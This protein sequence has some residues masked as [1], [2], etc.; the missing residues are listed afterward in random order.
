MGKSIKRV[1]K[2]ACGNLS[3][4]IR[5]CEHGDHSYLKYSKGCSGFSSDYIDLPPFTK[6]NEEAKGLG[7]TGE[8]T[9]VGRVCWEVTWV[10]SAAR[11]SAF[12][13]SEMEG[14]E[15]C[16]VRV[17]PGQTWFVKENSGPWWRISVWTRAIGGD[18]AGRLFQREGWCLLWSWRVVT[19][20][21]TNY[22]WRELERHR[23]WLQ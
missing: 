15:G 10:R 20:V 2:W 4:S 21:L 17:W 22:T 9:V 12:S 11:T 3:K 14:T 18:W 19:D 8:G 5:G 1:R 6:D 23:E 7:Q 16:W 13:V